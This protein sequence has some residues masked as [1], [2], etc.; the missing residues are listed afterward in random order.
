MGYE[1]ELA[2]RLGKK[3]LI[4]DGMDLN[5]KDADLVYEKQKRPS[6]EELKQE[7]IHLLSFVE[8]DGVQDL[9]EWAV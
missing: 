7:F 5:G 3:F 2:H 6:A 1:I 8:R 4:E 9:L